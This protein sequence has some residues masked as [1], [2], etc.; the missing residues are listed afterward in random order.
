MSVIPTVGLDPAKN[1]F[2]GL[3][4]DGTGREIGKLGH[5]VRPTMRFFS[6]KSSEWA[7]N[8]DPIGTH[9]RAPR[10]RVVR[11]PAHFGHAHFPCPTP[12]H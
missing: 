9:D 2:Q 6:V 12:R 10:C 8:N 1:V 7:P 11:T 5:E 4:A 3:G